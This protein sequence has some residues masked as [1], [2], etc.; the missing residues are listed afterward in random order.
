MAIQLGVKLKRVSPVKTQLASVEPQDLSIEGVGVAEVC[1]QLKLELCKLLGMS[2]D[3]HGR[4][5]GE[6]V[7]HVDGGG[8]TVGVSVASKKPHSTYK[9]RHPFAVVNLVLCGSKSWTLQHEDRVL[10]GT[11]VAGHILYL[12]PGW[13]HS[14]ESTPGTIAA[15]M[16]L[17]APH[18]SAISATAVALNLLAHASDMLY[19]SAVPPAAAQAIVRDKDKWRVQV[20]V[21]RQHATLVAEGG[22]RTV[23]R[24][25]S[26][27]WN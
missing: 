4:L 11:V 21:W 7:E 26:V 6:L 22:E 18:E 14:V 17:V 19:N 13:C 9:H 12:P 23:R 3:F 2:E 16:Y 8:G 1:A 25:A 5:L 27:L 24:R 10:K 20:G 15:H